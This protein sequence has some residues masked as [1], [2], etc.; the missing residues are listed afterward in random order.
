MAGRAIRDATGSIDMILRSQLFP[1]LQLV[2]T[3]LP[4]HVVNFRARPQI[5]F[6]LAMALQTPLHVKGLRTPG[7]RHLVDA[8]VAGGTSDT[9]R[10]V[11]AV[12]EVNK[13]RQVVHASPLDRG[14]RGKALPDGLERRG[15]RPELRMTGH[16]SLRRRHSGEGRFFDRSMAIAA[17]DAVI[18]HM[19]FVAE[20]DWLVEWHFYIS[21]PRRPKN[22]GSSPTRAAQQ[23]H[24]AD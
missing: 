6:R 19:M 18:D 16:A 17:V 10:D 23:N 21:R 8:A 5:F 15:F 3:G 9:F 7:D 20:G 22:S 24:G 12:I 14:A 4:G 1:L 13:I 11:D 2:R